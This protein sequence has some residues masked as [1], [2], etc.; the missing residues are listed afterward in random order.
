MPHPLEAG[1]IRIFKTD[2]TTAG[3]GFLVSKRL[4]VTCAHVVESA[5]KKPGEIIKFKYHLGNLD[6]QVAKVL[7]SGW[8]Y[9]NDV[10]VLEL[11]DLPPKWIRPIIMQ[12]S[13]AMEGR[14]FQGLGYPDD[15]PVQ[16][17]WS[18]G[19]ISG[20]VEAKGYANPLLQIQGKE[21]D[22]GL[23]G[24]AVVDRTTRRV[25][26]M[27]T[28]YQDIIRPSTAENVRFGYAVSME[29]IW[30]VYPELEKELPPLPKRSPLVEGI[31]LLPNGYDFRVQNFLTEYLGTPEQPE[32]FGG[33]EDALKKLDDW[34]DG[35]T[36]RLMLAAP[37]GRGKSALLV[38]WL[39][40]LI[41]REDLALVFVPVSVRFR[42][43]LASTF[44]ASLAA[45][46]AYL[47]GEDPSS[48]EESTDT[49]RGLVNT[50]LAR[51]LTDERK[52]LVVL[53]G[54]DETGD[55]EA[56]TDLIPA[57]LPDN[58][59][60]VASARFL[61]GDTDAKPW[62]SRLGW[63]HK[64]KAASFN[65][66]P[67][68]LFGVADVLQR[69][70]VPLGILSHRVDI[71]AE[72]HRLSEGDPLLV[73]LYV[74]D[75]WS[76]GAQ[77]A[78]LQPEDLR[79]IKPGYE[80][81]FDRW[82]EDQKKLWGKEKPWLLKHVSTVRQ[83][84]VGALGMLTVDDL[85]E[86]APE[87]DS[88]IVEDAIDILKRFVIGIPD[89]RRKSEIGYVLTH[90]KLRDYFWDKLTVKEQTKLTARFIAWG[91]CT[92]QALMDGDLNSAATPRYLLQYFGVHLEH[93]NA[94]TAQF[95]PFIDYPYWH[96]AWFEYEGA[97]GGYLQDVRRTSI[98]C[99][100][101]NQ[102]PEKKAKRSL[103]GEEIRCMLIEAS[104]GNRSKN[105]FPELV[106][107]CVNRNIWSLSQ[108][109][110]N[111]IQMKNPEKQ[112]KSLC[113]L[114]PNL[115][116][117]PLDEILRI[118][119][120]IEGDFH[121]TE[122]YCELALRI[123]LEDCDK[124]VKIARDTPKIRDQAKLMASLSRR[125]PELLGETLSL[126]RRIND[127]NDRTE[128][129]TVLI[130]GLPSELMS[131]IFPLAREIISQYQRGWLLSHIA[132]KIPA[133][134][135]DDML[136]TAEESR[137][138]NIMIAI[139]KHRPS[140]LDKAFTIAFQDLNSSPTAELLGEVILAL[141]TGLAQK[142]FTADRMIP[143][144]KDQAYS[145]A[146]VAGTP[147]QFFE[148]WVEA[149][150][151]IEDTEKRAYVLSALAK[152]RSN[153]TIE[154]LQTIKEI[155]HEA[156][157]IRSYR[158]MAKFQPRVIKRILPLIR[159]TG[160]PLDRASA[161]G[162]LARLQPEL[163]EEAYQAALDVVNKLSVSKLLCDLIKDLSPE[164][165]EDVLAYSSPLDNE[166]RTPVLINLSKH[167]SEKLADKIWALIQKININDEDRYYI[168]KSLAGKVSAAT[169]REMLHQTLLINDDEQRDELLIE[170]GKHVSPGR[171]K[172]IFESSKQ[173]AQ[174]RPRINTLWALAQYC[175]DQLDELLRMRKNIKNAEPSAEVLNILAGVLSPKDLLKIIPLAGGIHDEQMRAKVLRTLAERHLGISD[176]LLSVARKIQDAGLRTS[177]LLILLEEKPEL[178]DE[179]VRDAR[180]IRDLEWR[181]GTLSELEEYDQELVNEEIKIAWEITDEEIRAST[182]VQI[183][184]RHPH[185]LHHAYRAIEGISNDYVR[186]L[187]LIDL[188]KTHPEE[189][190]RKILA[191]IGTIQGWS[192]TTILRELIP[193]FKPELLDDIFI[194]A[195]QIDVK[196]ARAAALIALCDRRPGTYGDALSAIEAMWEKDDEHDR[197]DALIALAP[198]LPRMHIARA[199][200]IA[201][202][203][204]NEYGHAMTLCALSKQR[205][206]LINE[207]LKLIPKI[208]TGE[209]RADA[210]I[211]LL[212][213]RP[214]LIS[215]A[216]QEI[217]EI[218]DHETRAHTLRDLISVI[219]DHI[220]DE[221][222]TFA[223]E[224]LDAENSSMVL[225]ALS[226]YKPELLR[227]ALKTICQIQDIE[228]RTKYVTEL[229]MKTN[230]EP[231]QLFFIRL[232]L[233]KAALHSRPLVLND[234]KACINSEYSICKKTAGDMAEAV[235]DVTTWWP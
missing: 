160:T 5:C 146:G 15:G 46:L 207:V 9:E 108:T 70:G 93:A 199:I 142:S 69:M 13:I 139:S 44:F 14:A 30:K 194:L 16:T 87:L 85:G 116:N 61:A 190:L 198:K 40:R 133:E 181:V 172:Y 191:M 3:T 66:N 223:S 39:D 103:F 183:A 54:L 92:M 8:S 86:L 52:L 129:L 47:H 185:L 206:T 58:I 200:R 144:K 209:G 81:Y 150:R 138:I 152:I 189:N 117:I 196:N 90:P 235:C 49:W 211:H 71:A 214:D 109:F 175:P 110:A 76:R 73:N 4:A 234:I 167:A 34:L 128:L 154:A 176:K 208:Y 115:E 17:R 124:L 62:L 162:D 55:W 41:A 51:K 48:K 57:E 151:C 64:G 157:R 201:K 229:T 6:I 159:T 202:G 84:L 177:V 231:L 60:V 153:L 127:E 45:R 174:H 63:E 42:T 2:G 184:N 197:A 182:L 99:Q 106:E 96:R 67:L 217:K 193:I 107:A 89:E 91:R 179:V 221:L 113:L 169:L 59:H 123:P 219:G 228:T 143:D 180:K 173:A 164:R 132:Q 130:D 203:I 78:R 88:D 210:Y 23:S 31:H 205:P 149:A 225:M 38:R 82:W 10:A 226:S 170:L 79:R 21:I 29:T 56:G 137:D 213:K 171:L 122:V 121:R 35:D 216:L 212:D 156:G 26:G 36:Q 166:Y 120:Q 20:R 118:T 94:P 100:K 215:K 140:I 22:K 19:N 158:A 147:N 98:S 95:L 232:L 105:L 161:L 1:T 126:I 192:C 12:S 111:I 187:E 112:A 11:T 222:I 77:S 53:D 74:E 24:S 141:P 195:N 68:D 102:Q 125:K 28:A 97:Y 186:A 27:I 33:R 65:L 75:I 80:G 43:N 134:L 7:K 101:A 145:R 136:Q 25:I 168:S 50:Y 163:I 83:I 204:Q 32:P 224:S 131:G 165:L 18:Q 227:E 155:S 148:K 220:P 135:F 37:A 178:F 188:V 230:Q 104:L 233:S 114:T 119:G 72:L 218:T